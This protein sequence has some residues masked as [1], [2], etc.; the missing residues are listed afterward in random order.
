MT[1]ITRRR[2]SRMGNEENNSA[3]S[4]DMAREKELENQ[5]LKIDKKSKKVREPAWL[6]YAA[7]RVTALLMFFLVFIPGLNPAKITALISKNLSLFTS[8]I[9]YSSLTENVG[10]GFRRGWVTEDSFQLLFVGAILTLIGIIIIS[11][12]ACVN[13]GNLKC[14]RLS[15][16]INIIGLI[17]LSVGLVIV[18][19]AYKE[20]K[21]AANPDKVQAEFS[22]GII[23]YIVLG[24]IILVCTIVELLLTPL[25]PRKMKFEMETKFK[26]F[27]MFLPF[28]IL[29]FIFCYL[30]LWGW[31]Y[32]FFDYKAG[33]ELTSKS[34]VGFKWFKYLFQNS[35]TRME[36][37]RVLKNTLAMSGLGILTSWIPLAFAVLLTEIKSKP[38]KRIVQTFTTIPNFISWI[39]V[40]T[41]ALAIFSTDGFIN[42]I[43]GTTG[44]HLMGD[45]FTWL[46]M[47]A[48]GIWKGVGWGAII[49]IAGIAGI[50]KQLYEAA[51]VDGA[52][53][54]QRIW[55]VTIP[56]LMP[57]FMVMLL[58]SVAGMLSNGLDQYLVFSNASNMN[59]MEVLDLY[60]YHLGFGGGSIPLSTVIGMAKSIVSVAL[61]FMANGISKMVR[62]ESII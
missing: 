47:L 35:A 15:F 60:V 49:Y 21:N 32:S 48:W 29:A 3:Y 10:R 2:D 23:L 51:T 43:F 55:N 1:I 45:E 40:Y 53:R 24:S 56:G 16:L 20:M 17:L 30:P 8:A 31:R 27:L 46:K 6:V 13:L 18:S 61:L 33:D 38:F 41:V 54:F 62:K 37:V 58:L 57:T 28:A 9:S 59:H 11:G 36:L 22:S 39:L 12:G 25:P 34:F 14:K 7:H 42:T 4:V 44:N 19:N 5:V 26:L 50:D 52:G